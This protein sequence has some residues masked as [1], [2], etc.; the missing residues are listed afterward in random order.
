MINRRRTY[1]AHCDRD[2][3]ASKQDR[4]LLRWPHQHEAFQR[5][6]SLLRSGLLRYEAL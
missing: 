3:S 1:V 5:G 4:I 6:C 2:G